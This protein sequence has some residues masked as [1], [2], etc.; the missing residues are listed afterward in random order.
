VCTTWLQK[1]ERDYYLLDVYRARLTYPD[2]RRAVVHLFRRY[3]PEGIV[4]ENKGSGMSLIDDLYDEDLPDLPQLWRFDPD[5]D[6]VTRVVQVSA[7][8]ENG[9]VYLP[10]EAPW[11]ED[12]HRELVLFPRGRHDDQVDSVSQ[13]LNWAEYQ[14]RHRP[15]VFLI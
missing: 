12:F 9:H 5:A 15:R 2:L 6:K 7:L 3:G 10:R 8:I 11:L 4:I 13:F 1:G 14:R